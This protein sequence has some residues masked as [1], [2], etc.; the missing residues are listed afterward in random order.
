M[1]FLRQINFF[2]YSMC[3]HVHLLLIHGCLLQ[4]KFIHYF[5]FKSKHCYLKCIFSIVLRVNPISLSYPFPFVLPLVPRNR[6]VSARSENIPY[7]MRRHLVT[8]TS[9]YIVASWLLRHPRR[10]ELITNLLSASVC[11][12][13]AW[14]L[15]MFSLVGEMRDCCANQQCNISVEK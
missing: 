5:Y 13:I 10:Q 3:F 2:F 14:V 8:V 6:V 4:T 11:L 7:E 9:S 12:S 15:V 1:F